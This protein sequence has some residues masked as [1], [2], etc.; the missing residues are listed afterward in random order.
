MSSQMN[1]RDALT[2]LSKKLTDVPPTHR[3]TVD[4]ED[5]YKKHI[6][7]REEDVNAL[8]DAA[9]AVS[10]EPDDS[11]VLAGVLNRVVDWEADHTI[12][13]MLQAETLDLRYHLAET[14]DEWAEVDVGPLCKRCRQPFVSHDIKALV[15]ER[16]EWRHEQRETE[17][18]LAALQS[19][20]DAAV[21]AE[22]RL[23]K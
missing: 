2:G 11:R 16:D 13:S 23:P 19:R 3:I 18:A 10:P 5:G 6:L 22:G 9:L 4:T 17:K 14:C 12:R 1:N 15:K 7:V 20:F 8:V 21:A